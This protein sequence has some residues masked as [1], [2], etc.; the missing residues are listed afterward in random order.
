M[1]DGKEPSV[2]QGKEST[3]KTDLPS[4]CDFLV[5]ERCNLKCKKCYFWRNGYWLEDE[6]TFEECRDF[7]LSLK[8]WVPPTFELNLGGG[9]TLLKQNMLDLIELCAKEG[10]RASISTNATLIDEDMAKRIADAGLWRLG[11]SLDTLDENTQDFLTGV[12]GSYKRVTNAIGYLKKHWKNGHINI[13]AVLSNRN[14]DSIKDLIEWVNKEEFLTGISVMA[15]SQP[16]RTEPIDQWY[17]DKEYGILWPTDFAKVSVVLDMLVAY[18]KAGY[19]ILNAMPQLVAYK[20]YYENP[21]SF[22]RAHDCHFGDYTFNVNVLGLVMLCC[23][24]RP[25]GNIKKQSIR[26]IWNSEAAV[27]TRAAMRNCQKS[28]NNI[29]NCFF[30]E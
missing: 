22:V 21:E 20:K 30:S 17:L 19:R 6:V 4:Y 18:K 9:E 3:V 26:D 13:H 5:T 7:I 24:M 14:L 25:V 1:S 27:K 23:F 12:P 8:G 2:A 28:C 11:V 16:F 15:L 10:I 29:L